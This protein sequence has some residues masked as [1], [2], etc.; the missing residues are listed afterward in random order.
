MARGSVTKRGDAW[1][2]AVELEPD[3]ETGKRRQRFETFHGSKK[4]ADNRLVEL[5]SQVNQHQIGA[6]PKLTIAEYLDRWL[7]DHVSARAPKT[8]ASYGFMA[9]AYVVPHL[10]KVQLSKLTPSHVA[11]FLSTLRDVPRSD[12]KEGKL[13]PATINATYRAL[14]AALNTAV[15]WQLI[16]TN[17]VDAVETPSVPRKEMRTFTVE[18]AQAFLAASAEE[19]VKW[20]AFFTLWLHAGSRPGELKALKWEH[21]DL[22]SG[23]VSIQQHAQ[24]VRGVGKVIGQPKTSYGR[25][26]VALGPDVVAL[27]RRQRAEQNALRLSLGPLWQDNG[28]VFPSEVG[29]ILE[30]KRVHHTFQRICRRAG[31]PLIRPYDLRH[32]SASLL[33]AAG[34]HPKV[35]AERLGHSN[36]NLT[37]STYSHVLPGLQRDAAETLEAMMRKAR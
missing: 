11:R 34:V 18:Q 12:G 21:L 5:L 7:T 29:S 9:R 26:P 8:H 31:V 28:L 4:E 30:D 15:K 3:P 20:Q 33:L 1:R 24:R 6:S 16:P 22:E 23:T 35:V 2:I 10:G 14:H 25:R 37:L 13:S 32:S 19:G 17:P 27:L 36:V